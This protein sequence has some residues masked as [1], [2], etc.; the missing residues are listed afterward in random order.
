LSGARLTVRVHAGARRELLDATRPGP[1]IVHVIAPAHEG[2][3][4]RAVRRLLAKR[5]GLAPTRLSIVRGEHARDKVIEID[6]IE[7]DD[8]EELLSGLQG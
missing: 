1:L 3:A 6:G 8:L 7:Q 5:L 4:N 2:R